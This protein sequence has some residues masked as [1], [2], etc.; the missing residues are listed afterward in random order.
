MCLPSWYLPNGDRGR[1]QGGGGIR[2]WAIVQFRLISPEEA[3]GL[4]APPRR[5]SKKVRRGPAEYCADPSRPLLRCWRRSARVAVLLAKMSAYVQDRQDRS[6]LILPS[7]LRS[8]D[9]IETLKYYTNGPRVSY[10]ISKVPCT[11]R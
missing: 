3:A 7:F 6:G 11:L 4:P 2:G 8:F 9:N 5:G 10:L 1:I